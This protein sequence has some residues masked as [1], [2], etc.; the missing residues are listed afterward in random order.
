MFCG[1]KTWSLAIEPCAAARKHPLW[2]LPIKFVSWQKH[3]LWQYNICYGHKPS[4]IAIQHDIT[5]QHLLSHKNVLC[6]HRKYVLWPYMVIDNCPWIMLGG[7]RTCAMAIKHGPWAKNIAHISFCGHGTCTWPQNIFFR[8]DMF[9][10]HTTD[11]MTIKHILW[12]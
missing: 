2:C 5:N 10:S 7:H 11:S 8:Y 3:V 12:P 6:G 4:S 1:Q 9:S